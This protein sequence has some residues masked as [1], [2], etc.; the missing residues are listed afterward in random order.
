MQNKCNKWIK[1]INVLPNHKNTKYAN[2]I[3]YTSFTWSRLGRQGDTILI[4]K[5]YFLMI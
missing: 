3:I 5:T 1:Y 2:G 4:V